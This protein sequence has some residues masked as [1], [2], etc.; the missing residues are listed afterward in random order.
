MK[1]NELILHIGHAKTGTTSLQKTLLESREYLEKNGVLYPYVPHFNGNAI[2]L[3][4]HLFDTSSL[5][6]PRKL[7]MGLSQEAAINTAKECWDTVRAR[8]SQGGIDKVVISSEHFFST[9]DDDALERAK[10]HFLD[11]ADKIKIVAYVR[12]PA[13]QYLSNRQETLKTKAGVHVLRERDEL[14]KNLA[15]WA[16]HFPDS[17]SVNIFGRDSLLNDDIVSD[18]FAR[19][20]P[21]LD[22]ALLAGGIKRENTSLSAEAMA[23]LQDIK[24]GRI[25]PKYNTDTVIALVRRNDLMVA[26]PTKPK[27]F[28]AIRQGV[29]DWCAP[30]LLWLQENYGIIF[31]DIDYATINSSTATPDQFDFVRIEDIC[32]VCADRKAR[33]WRRARIKARLPATLRRWAARW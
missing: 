28:P 18:F 6:R 16:A 13:A 24:S 33:L 21:D 31:P 25:D 15:R 5:E 27:L 8:V 29:I 20:L 17:M 3:G 4:Y 1:C 10:A 23:L 11:I 19:N 14:A 26:R 30:D 32:T 12:S 9:F 2:L 7:W 22:R